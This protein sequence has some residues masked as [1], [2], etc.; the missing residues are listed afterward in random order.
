V[1]IAFVYDAVYPWETG[2]VQK[3]VWEIARRLAD[4]HDVHWFGLH[5]WDGPPVVQRENV[6]L[7]GVAEPKDLYVDGRRSITEALYFAANLVGPLTDAEFDLVDCQAF[8]YFSCYTSA[9]STLL[10]GA[11]YVVTWHEVWQEYWYEYLGYAGIFGR[12]IERGAVEL[13]DEHLVV[14]RQTGRDLQTLRGGKSK[15]YLLPNGIDLRSID[16]TAPADESVDV[17]FVGRF[18]QEK[19]PDLLVRAI[20][21]LRKRE[22]DVQCYLVGQGPERESVAALVEALGLEGN[23]TMLGFRDT[24][25]EIIAL[26]KAADVFA[27]PSRREGF[28]IT[29]LEAL[30]A[31]TPVVTIDHP[32]NAATALVSDGVTGYVVDAEPDVLATVLEDARTDLDPRACRE[33]AADYDWDRI[34]DQAETLYRDIVAKE[35]VD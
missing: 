34:A 9:L 1:K 26:M 23:V 17:L 29:V 13:P 8:P 28:G 22:P 6:V 2:G 11:T 10:N 12:V 30:A 3:R 24:H 25:E 27:L 14:S 7:H 35:R 20:G 18:I 31:G 5:Y 32:G 21:R 4:D 15:S 16:D 19:N 33:S